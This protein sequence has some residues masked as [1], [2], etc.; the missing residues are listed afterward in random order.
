[1]ALYYRINRNYLTFLFRRKKMRHFTCIFWAII[2][3]ILLGAIL[4]SLPIDPSEFSANADVQFFINNKSPDGPVTINQGDST[5]IGL[6]IYL[7]KNFQRVNITSSCNSYYK[8]II[9]DL[10]KSI[11]TVNFGLRFNG[12]GTCTLFANAIMKTALLNEKADTLP[13]IIK[14]GQADNEQP[15]ILSPS[16]INAPATIIAGIA[17]TLLFSIDNRNRPNPLRLE[18]INTAELI[19]AVFTVLRSGP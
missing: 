11:D 5:D 12:S 3:P 7:A 18:L 8:A 10:R 14:S 2:L 4:C 15:T 16:I 1:M 6:E 19:P 17:D 13:F 9:P